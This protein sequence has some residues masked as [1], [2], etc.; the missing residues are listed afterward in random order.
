MSNNRDSISY[1]NYI[2]NF[3]EFDFIRLHDE[4]IEKCSKL[5]EESKKIKEPTGKEKY[6][7]YYS[8]AELYYYES[9]KQSKKY[10]FSDGTLFNVDKILEEKNAE[11]LNKIIKY[12]EISLENYKKSWDC[13]ESFN[14]SGNHDRIKEGIRILSQELSIFYY[15]LEDE[16]KFFSYGKCAIEFNSLNSIYIFLKYYCDNKDYDNAAVYY[17]LMNKYILGMYN[18]PYQDTKLKD[19]SYHIYYKF[20]YDSGEYENALEVVKEYKKFIINNELIEN[21]LKFT[22]PANEIIEQCQ[23][24]INKSKQNYYKEDILL[25]YFDKETLKII[26]E[27]NKIY[28]LTSLNI[29]EYMKSTEITMDYSAALMPIL[30]VIENIMFEIIA[31]K[32]HSFVMEKRKNSYIN[33]KDIKGFINQKEKTFIEKIEQLELG[34][35]QHLIGY[36]HPET[37]EL[38]IRRIFV[39]F[40]I[41]NGIN[42]PRTIIT[43]LFNELDEL[44]NKRNLVAHKNRVFEEVVTE[45]YDILLNNI[46]FINFLYTNFRFVFEKNN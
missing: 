18:D 14:I 21:K 29:Y 44:R 40:C 31:K 46:K 7:F 20:L 39:D 17:N 36:N 33:P 8:L 11:N 24:L 30:K 22:R 28:I 12:K 45:C 15:I 19:R 34:S 41:A 37:N 4:K 1:N 10:D 9:M 13:I 3:K 27:D 43:T 23:L 32:Y 26:S 42:N 16:E 2:K 5:L 6:F 35:A 25:K 38:I